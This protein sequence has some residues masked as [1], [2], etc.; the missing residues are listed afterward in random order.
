[1]VKRFVQSVRF[2]FTA[3]LMCTLAIWAVAKF[4]AFSKLAEKQATESVITYAQT[5]AKNTA[6]TVA[7]L[8]AFD[9]TDSMGR[10]LKAVG[11]DSD[12]CY[13][14]LFKKSGEVA[15]VFER[16]K[17]PG[18][19]KS[20]RIGSYRIDN[21]VHVIVP[22][23][24]LGEQWG[25]LAISLSLDQTFHQVRK[26][27]IALLGISTIAAIA[28]LA[29]L[30][31]LINQ[32]VLKPLAP[33]HAATQTLAQGS[34]PAPIETGLT[35]EIGALTREFNRMVK[36]LENAESAKR[37]MREMEQSKAK[38][39]EASR[40][41]SEFLANMSHELRTP[42]NGIIGMTELALDTPLTAEQS[43]Y[44]K[45]VRSSADSLL[46]ILNDVLDFSKIDAGKLTLSPVETDLCELVDDTVRLLAVQAEQ[47][48]L[49]L[50]SRFRPDVPRGVLCDPVRVRQILTNLIG[51]AIKFTHQGEV[52]LLVE[53]A[54]GNPDELVLQF[55]IS[56]TGIGI[57]PE[58]RAKIFESFVQ[59]DGSTTRKYGGT[60]LGLAI[61]SQLV[62]MM[63]GK[64]WVESEPDNGSTFFF[65]VRLEE[66]PLP[67]KTKVAD[68]QRL[69]GLK[70]LIVDDN[71]TNRT[72]L[73]ELLTRWGADVTLASSGAEA[74]RLLMDS[75][76]YSLIITDVQMPGMDGFHLVEEIHWKYAPH[77]VILMLSSIG[78]PEQ[79]ARCRELGVAAY[80]SK[81]VTK[82]ALLQAVLQALG[83]SQSG[84]EQPEKKQVI[85]TDPEKSSLRI[86]VAED[87]AVNQTLAR[88]ILEKASHSVRVVPNGK[89]ALESIEEEPFDLVLMDVQMPVLD[90]LQATRMIR[91]RENQTQTRLPIIGLTAHALQ[92]DR[93]MCLKAGMDEYISKPLNYISLLKLI[94]A[95]T[96]SRTTQ[97]DTERPQTVHPSLAPD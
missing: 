19:I 76:V 32:I 30:L 11:H 68:V 90:G 1:M 97:I 36:E 64:I 84:L 28:V 6:F 26:I 55:S 31:W 56:D 14:V 80:L 47:K 20:A 29:A 48:G 41:K 42:M 38:A 70:T 73:N 10:V 18:W 4:I 93:E 35:D 9:N 94:E 82:D 85:T 61:S 65:T 77:A 46:A 57:R 3:G 52:S 17:V 40:L 22:V 13:A 92:G 63:G 67:G 59:A 74:L 37:L 88:R 49:E 50:I 43:E 86:L 54:S 87:N 12:V 95:V 83:G 25:R 91:E 5:L 39:E 66:R 72:L 62:A 89:A 53:R 58:H 15:A 69:E 7:P 27:Q 33:L 2:K 75:P 51:N 23:E 60:G 96:E 8:L 78:L 71:A 24:D 16:R 44:L 45:V 21:A 34:F 79:T 81:P